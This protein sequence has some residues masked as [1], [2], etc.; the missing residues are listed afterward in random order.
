VLFA[1]AVGK[2]VGVVVGGIRVSVGGTGVA[3]G[4]GGT[5]V[6]TVAVQAIPPMTTRPQTAI[7]AR[8]GIRF[9]ATEILT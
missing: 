2:A 5:G 3:V 1:V 9:L 7:T 4:V 8:K 6:G